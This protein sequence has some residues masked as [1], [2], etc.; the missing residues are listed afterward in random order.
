MKNINIFIQ[1][2]NNFEQTFETFQRHSQ[3]PC[4]VYSVRNNNHVFDTFLWLTKLNKTA[5]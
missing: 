5:D 1:Q 4:Q 2:V 3:E